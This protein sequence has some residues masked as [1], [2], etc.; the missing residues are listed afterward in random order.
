MMLGWVFFK[1]SEWSQLREQRSQALTQR[2]QRT[3][4]HVMSS[5]LHKKST[6]GST[7]SK[8]CLSQPHDI[9]YGTN[10]DP[11]IELPT[12]HEE[13]SQLLAEEEL[14]LRQL[15]HRSGVTMPPGRVKPDGTG[16]SQLGLKRPF[17]GSMHKSSSSTAQVLLQKA[18]TGKRP[19]RG[20]HD[21][22]GPSSRRR[23]AY[24]CHNVPPLQLNM[25]AG[26]HVIKGGA[27]IRVAAP[28]AGEG[29]STSWEDI[30][31]STQNV[32]WSDIAF[33]VGETAKPPF[34]LCRV[35]VQADLSLLL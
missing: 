19:R 11:S 31:L 8:L 2:E 29:S 20:S 13:Y 7:L 14:L 12:L 6:V 9:F 34:N 24:S 16:S 28:A 35:A 18:R 33:Q 4:E 21:G 15:C 26:N 10:S 32:P 27:R 1:S 3:I 5:V 22:E 30:T 23:T 25:P 17:P